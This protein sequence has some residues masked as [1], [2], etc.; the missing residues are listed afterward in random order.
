MRT[1]SILTQS[2][3]SLV[4]RVKN[5]PF[6]M[7]DNARNKPPSMPESITERY[8]AFAVNFGFL[9]IDSDF[10]VSFLIFDIL[11]P[12]PLD[13]FLKLSNSI[14]I[15]YVNSSYRRKYDNCRD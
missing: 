7:I 4:N 12:N 1:V 2:R 5:S 9:F 6:N 15:K 8:A 14:Y 3:S 10:A 13:F 11:T